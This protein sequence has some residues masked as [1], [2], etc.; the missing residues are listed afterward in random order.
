MLWP[1]FVGPSYRARSASIANELAINVYPEVTEIA[2]EAKRSTLYGTPG[3]RLLLTVGTAS[4]RGWFSQDGRTFVVVGNT[5]YELNLT[6]TVATSYGTILDDGHPVSFA[7]NG[8]GGEQLAICGGGQ[9]KIFTLTT[10]T[11]G[12]AVTLPMTNAPVML[13]FIDG[14]FLANEVN[15]VRVWFSALENGNSWDALDFFAKSDTSDNIVGIIASHGRLWVHSSQSTEVYYDSGD[16]DNPFLPYPGSIMEEGA[17]TPWAIVSMGGAIMW[18][19][20][21]NRGTSRI[22][23]ANVS[24]YTTTVISTPAISVAL[25]SYPRLDDIETLAYEQEGH[26]FVAFTSPSGDQTFVWDVR[27]QMWHQRDCIDAITGL[28]KKW[29]AR[30]S[31]ASGQMILTG[32]FVTGSLY[33]LEL[34]VFTDSCGP[35]RRLRRAPYVSAENQWLFIDRLELG[36]QSGVGLITGQGVDPEVMLSLSRDSGA[37]WTPP[38]TASIGR[39]GQTL[40][41]AIWRRLGRARADRLVI[42]ITQTDAVRTVWGPGLW[43]R[44][45]PGTGM[46]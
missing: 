35:I 37:T 43:M 18:L 32:D 6:T 24:G 40:A 38:V 22:V 42:E 28:S 2:N 46:L 41:R 11:L 30:G 1:N 36:I 17:V 33:A 26:P 16:T 39:L 23:S 21:D 45:T 15:T 13:A 19:A 8:R 29:S 4:C 3:L 9:I 12:A 34:D 31:A 25:A 7:S 10:S 20:Q 14:Y 5:F 44:V 27:E